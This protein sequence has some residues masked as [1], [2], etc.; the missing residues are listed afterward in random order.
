MI[1]CV[2]GTGFDILLGLEWDGS[3]GTA[4]SK[5]LPY[6]HAI[7][8]G[9]GYAT[10]FAGSVRASLAGGL[11]DELTAQ[12]MQVRSTAHHFCNQLCDDLTVLMHAGGHH[13]VVHLPALRQP[14]EWARPFVQ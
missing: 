13:G 5:T 1:V 4:A 2:Q 14:S 3:S 10:G 12:F 6:W 8:G 9:Y 7:Y 11:C